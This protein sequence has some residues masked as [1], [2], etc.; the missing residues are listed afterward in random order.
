MQSE[1]IVHISKRLKWQQ[2]VY[3]IKIYQLKPLLLMLSHNCTN[4]NTNSGN[5]KYLEIATL[6]IQAYLEMG[7]AY[8]DGKELYESVLEKLGTTRELK[9][10]RKF[11][12]AKKDK[13]E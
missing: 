1:E 6:H 8:E 12:S 3:S 9:F 4:I 11:Y 2:E 7:F 5:T 10:P 13:I